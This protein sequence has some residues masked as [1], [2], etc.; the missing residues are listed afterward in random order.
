[1]KSQAAILKQNSDIYVIETRKDGFASQL[2][3]EGAKLR[4]IASWDG[5]WD[6]VS[7]SLW[8]RCP[9]WNEMQFVKDAFFK[10][11]EI[12]MQLHPGTKDYICNHEFCL[13]IWRPQN[14]EIPIPPK[15]YV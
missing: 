6:H 11:T 14:Q 1:M 9:T 15:V 12:A 3:L 7:I 2:F 8:D 10:P 4:I 5:G 13:H